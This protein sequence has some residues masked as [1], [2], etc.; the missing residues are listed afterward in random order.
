MGIP[1]KIRLIGPPP[2]TGGLPA[3]AT[4]RKPDDQSTMGAAPRQRAAT[5][6]LRKLTAKLIDVGCGVPLYLKVYYCFG[7]FP[8]VGAPLL[9]G[10]LGRP[11]HRATVLNVHE[12]KSTL[13]LSSVLRGRWGL[14]P[15]FRRRASS[16]AKER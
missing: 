3:A 13:G 6:I 1:K 8:P 4:P 12:W 11:L 2:G 9:L 5:Q 7:R 14:F 16:G 15:P 10:A